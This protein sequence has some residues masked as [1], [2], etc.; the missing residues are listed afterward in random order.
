MKT[1]FKKLFIIATTFLFILNIAIISNAENDITTGIL[2][3]MEE[4]GIPISQEDAQ[5]LSAPNNISGKNYY[6]LSKTDLNIDTNVYGDVF[7]CAN[8]T[9]TINSTISGNVFVVAR[10]VKISETSEISASLFCVTQNLEI[11]GIIKGNCYIVSQETNLGKN[12]YINLDLYAVA[13]TLNIYGDI[14]RDVSISVNKIIMKEGSHINGDLYYSSENESEI[15]ENSVGGNINFSKKVTNEDNRV[16]STAKNALT[17]IAIISIIKKCLTHAIFALALF[18]ILKYI[19]SNIIT[20]HSNFN[21]NLGKYILFGFLVTFVSPILLLILLGI[22]LTSKVAFLLILAYIAFM[23]ISSSSFII[24]L[25]NMLAEKYK[26]KLNLSEN[27]KMVLLIS[28]LSIVYSLLGL[29]PVLGGLLKFAI[30]ILG[31]GIT[32]CSLPVKKL[33]TNIEEK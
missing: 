5:I 1:H 4:Y 9:V 6:A 33:N 29:I 10:E 27:L 25:A 24:V 14:N 28:I 32:V 23:L 21:A 8:G 3:N 20:E 19:G 22:G 30:I 7:V 16:K 12:G 31:V 13:D 2:Q 17:S 18:F 26:E 11:S 15:S